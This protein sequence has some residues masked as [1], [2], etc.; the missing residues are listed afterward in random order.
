LGGLH[1]RNAG[2]KKDEDSAKQS[3]GTQDGGMA[4]IVD[5]VIIATTMP[6]YCP[7]HVPP[8]EQGTFPSFSPTKPRPDFVLKDERARRALNTPRGLTTHK[9]EI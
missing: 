7:K 5:L 3:A 6:A 1:L 2:S 9:G 4:I 8:G